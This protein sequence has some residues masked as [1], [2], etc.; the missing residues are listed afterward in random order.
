MMGEDAHLEMAYE[1]RFVA[2][3]DESEYDVSP[4]VVEECELCGAPG[5]TYCVPGCEAFDDRGAEIDG[6]LEH[7]MEG[8]CCEGCEGGPCKYA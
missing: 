6:A 7:D 4:F 2:D 3:T 8:D 1:D 5:D